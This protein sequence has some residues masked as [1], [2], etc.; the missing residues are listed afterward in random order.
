M[1]H[2]RPCAWCDSTGITEKGFCAMCK[3]RGST[4][5]I[6]TKPHSNTCTCGCED[7]VNKLLKIVAVHTQSDEFARIFRAYTKE[8]S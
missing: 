4:E 2:S 6:E 5:V 1:S 7:K 8:T 3:G